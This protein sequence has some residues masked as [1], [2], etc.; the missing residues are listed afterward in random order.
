[1]SD[2]MRLEAVAQFSDDVIAKLTDAFFE[3]V[4]KEGWTKRDLAQISGVNETAIGH[5]LSGR[6]L[7]P[8]AET[9]ALLATAMRRRP[10]LVLKDARLRGNEFAPVTNQEL[11]HVSSAPAANFAIATPPQAAVRIYRNAIS[12]DMNGTTG[13]KVISTTK[14]SASPTKQARLKR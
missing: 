7:N 13:S 4:T 11:A 9:I 6:R 5:I 14:K 10:E 8:T 12:K 3:V 1:M 2:K